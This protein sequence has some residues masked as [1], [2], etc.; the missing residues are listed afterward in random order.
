M[1]CPC[2]GAEE[3]TR[4]VPLGSQTNPGA[5]T[6]LMAKRVLCKYRETHPIILVKY[7]GFRSGLFFFFFFPEAGII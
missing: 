7:P 3:I 4:A 6:A 2:S 1:A 5:P